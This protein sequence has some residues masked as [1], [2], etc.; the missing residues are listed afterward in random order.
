MKFYGSLKKSDSDK[1]ITEVAHII[2]SEA[3]VH[4][5]SIMLHIAKTHVIVRLDPETKEFLS[6][7]EKLSNIPAGTIKYA[8]DDDKKWYVLSIGSKNIITRD[9]SHKITGILANDI[10]QLECIGY[11]PIVIPQYEWNNMFEEGVKQKYLK[12]LL[13]R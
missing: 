6:P 7:S 12:N 1:I 5:D 3:A 2:K 13:F 9:E 11:T 4:V 10:R 8:P